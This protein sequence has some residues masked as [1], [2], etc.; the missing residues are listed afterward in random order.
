MKKF[1]I[2]LVCLLFI[3]GN[4]SAKIW[5]VNNNPGVTANFT[6][7][8]QANDNASVQNG[9]TI[10]LEPS[11]TSYGGLDAT[12]RLVWIS[13]G[14]F[15]DIH[16]G[17]QFSMN[18]GRLDNIALYQAGCENTILHV[19]VSGDIQAMKSGIRIDRCFVGS[20]IFTNTNDATPPANI[21]IIN[22][23]ISGTLYLFS[24]DNIL[25]TNNIVGCTVQMYSSGVSL[26]VLTNN[27]FNANQGCY[28]GSNFY[29][30]IV[31]NNIFCYLGEG[32][33]ITNST[34][35]YNM[36]GHP[37]GLPSGNNNQNNI[38]MTTVFVDPSTFV[39]SSFVLKAGSPAKGAGSGSPAVDLG[40][41]GGSSPFRL[42]MQ[43]P[44]PA[45]Y[46]IEAP[47]A[48]TGNTMNVIFS[49][50]SNN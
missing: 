6:T 23:F 21:V 14:A 40:A 16:P 17:E 35:G 41:F 28:S 37:S 3:A 24:G 42:A 38:D 36:S 33:G 8:Q 26:A 5:R 39:D 15:L 31:E 34:V 45:I 7:A 12:K 43:P 20:N 18:I 11:A 10:H 50:K 13:T 49:T 22:C 44:I 32:C 29:N 4:L 19:Y 48:P 9:D 46:K 30:S 27:V 1:F 25:A 47:A 2:F